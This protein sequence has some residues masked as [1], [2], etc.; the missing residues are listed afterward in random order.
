MRADPLPGEIFVGDHLVR[1]GGETPVRHQPLRQS[2]QH[3]RQWP[4][5]ALP[6]GAPRPVVIAIAEMPNPPLQ[7]STPRTGVE[8]GDQRGFLLRGDPV[9]GETG[10]GWQLGLG[11]HG[12]V[13][14]S[15]EWAS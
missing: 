13:S 11:L 1:H 12:R 10:T 14:L 9:G 4:D 7:L 2:L 3:V 6:R 15:V 5:P 8:E